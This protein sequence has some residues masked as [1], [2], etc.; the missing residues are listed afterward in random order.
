MQE[1]I[2]LLSSLLI[3]VEQ[4]YI[5]ASVCDTWLVCRLC[6]WVVL[7]DRKELYRSKMPH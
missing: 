5:S 1:S 2:Y 7:G 4:R 6:S 3:E